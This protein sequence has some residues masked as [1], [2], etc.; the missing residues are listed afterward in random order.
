[1]SDGEEA[2]ADGEDDAEG[3]AAESATG[4]ANRLRTRSRN[5][6]GRETR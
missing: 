6:M 1:M 5:W 3:G 4:T 2:E